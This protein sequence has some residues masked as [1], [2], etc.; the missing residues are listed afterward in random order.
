MRQG[1]SDSPQPEEVVDHY[2]SGYEAARLHTGTSQLDRERSRGL[3]KRF[4][5]PASGADT[6]V[7]PYSM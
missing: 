3:L 4:L 6:W 7:C 1:D 5:P 2:A